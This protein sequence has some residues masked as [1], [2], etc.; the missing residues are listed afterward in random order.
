MKFFTFLSNVPIMFYI[1]LFYVDVQ[2]GNPNNE[3]DVQDYN[4]N[5]DRASKYVI[6]IYTV[7][8]DSSS[9]ITMQ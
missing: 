8:Q 3:L 4:L 9:F 6:C 5:V 7:V 1:I 2:I